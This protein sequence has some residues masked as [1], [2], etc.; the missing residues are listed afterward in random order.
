MHA[1]PAAPP[2]A[3]IVLKGHTMSLGLILIIVLVIFLAGGF[4]GRFGGYGFGYGAGGGG[5]VVCIGCFFLFSRVGGGRFW[6]CATKKGRGLGRGGGLC[7]P[8][9][10]CVR[11]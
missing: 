8:P 6:C 10:L 5:G 2:S 11:G 1:C 4:R 3:H 9:P 7:A